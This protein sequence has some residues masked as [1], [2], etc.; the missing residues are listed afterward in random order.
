MGVAVA[1]RPTN[2]PR[3]AQAVIRAREHAEALVFVGVLQ[4]GLVDI[5]PGIT[6]IDKAAPAAAQRIVGA[7]GAASGALETGGALCIGPLRRIPA[8]DADDQASRAAPQVQ[9]SRT[10]QAHLR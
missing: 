5:A 9:Q 4:R 6:E 1:E 8:I 7:R 2:D 3:I 10:D